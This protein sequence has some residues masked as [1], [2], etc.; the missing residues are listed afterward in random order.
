MLRK[1][2]IGVVVL[3]VFVGLVVAL[4]WTHDTLGPWVAGAAMAV[5]VSWG[6]VLLASPRFRQ[7][8][9]LPPARLSSYFS[10]DEDD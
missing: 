4:R 1:L 2:T 10:L 7:P 3:A 5:L 8:T 6:A 9:D